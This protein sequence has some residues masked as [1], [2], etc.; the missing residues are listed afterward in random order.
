MKLAKNLFLTIL[1]VRVLSA[2]AFSQERIRVATYNIRFLKT[3]VSS[4]GDR[5]AKLREVITRLDARIIGLQEIDN[6]AALQLLFPP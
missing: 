3:A 4:Q 1:V 6:R 2:S 5:L